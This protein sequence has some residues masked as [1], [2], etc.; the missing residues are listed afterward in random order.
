MLPPIILALVLLGK[1]CEL[2]VPTTDHHAGSGRRLIAGPQPHPV[3]GFRHVRTPEW[4]AHRNGVP[5]RRRSEP[6]RSRDL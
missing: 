5:K 3:D 2:P 4:H 6:L 1:T